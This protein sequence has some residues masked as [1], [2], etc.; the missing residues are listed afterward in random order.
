MALLAP[1][2]REAHI[3]RVPVGKGHE[4]GRAD[5]Q[6][7]KR[8]LAPDIH[9]SQQNGRSR[10]IQRT[11]RPARAPV[12]ARSTRPALAC[13]LRGVPS[14]A[15]ISQPALPCPAHAPPHGDLRGSYPATTPHRGRDGVPAA[16]CTPHA[17][18]RAGGV[19]WTYAEAHDPIPQASARARR[20]CA[21]K[22]RALD[23]A[24]GKASRPVAPRRAPD[25]TQA[26]H[27]AVDPRRRTR[28]GAARRP[29]G[30]R[31]ATDR[32]SS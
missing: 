20:Q 24:G 3:L 12:R 21:D 7:G 11:R 19:W 17:C 10:W 14:R 23:L 1:N 6:T 9:N 25:E 22:S 32:H 8:R 13:R 5:E 30:P 16:L 27:R 18:V 28:R 31:S 4:A 15:R 2:G 29:R 26:P